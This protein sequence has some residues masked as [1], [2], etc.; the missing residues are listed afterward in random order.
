VVAIRDLDGKKLTENDDSGGPDARIEWT[1][2]RDGE[3]L[4]SVRDHRTQRRSS[5]LR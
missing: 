5:K 4:V 2:P 3:F 1:A